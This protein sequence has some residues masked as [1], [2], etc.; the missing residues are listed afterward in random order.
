MVDE[1]KTIDFCLICIIR[2]TQVA[3]NLMGCCLSNSDLNLS[4]SQAHDVLL[5]KPQTKK[6]QL[7]QSFYLKESEPILA[8]DSAITSI[9]V[10]K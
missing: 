8:N 1:N 9:I 7:H 2:L 3:Q 5:Y 6:I 4:Q 10:S